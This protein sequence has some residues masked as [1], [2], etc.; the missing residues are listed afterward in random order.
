[1]T[2]SDTRNWAEKLGYPEG[3]KVLILHADDAGLNAEA[4]QAIIN[5]L[6]DDE[7]QVQS[8]SV[9]VPC[10]A[11]EEFV[12][13]GEQ[14]GDLDIG[15]HLTMTSEW[16]QYRWKSLLDRKVFPELFYNEEHGTLLSD[17]ILKS[18][19][20]VAFYV[21]PEVL[22]LEAIAQISRFRE[23]YGKAPSHIDTHM[24]VFLS[25]PELAK[26]FLEL[27]LFTSTPVNVPDLSKAFAT[28]HFQ[29][30]KLSIEDFEKGKLKNLNQ[31]R[32]DSLFED[33]KI[34]EFIEFKKEYK[35]HLPM[36]DNF[37]PVPIVEKSS[38][39]SKEVSYKMKKEFFEEFVKSSIRPGLTELF[40]HPTYPEAGKLIMGEDK[41]RQRLE[42]GK[43]FADTKVKEFLQKEGIIFTNW[44]E[45]MRRYKARKK[46]GKI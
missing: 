41:W 21:D 30:N 22:K 28:V 16:G 20:E 4:N 23:V 5:Y 26:A 29:K 14:N 40:F 36:L 25:T 37:L 12:E 15:V 13:W 39:Y 19:Q 6:N 27:A 46:A 3:S 35:K 17:T 18:W 44:K 31:E 42:E 10:K 8:A 9:M 7:A 24:G 45:M 38:K 33:R 34:N 32:I 11:F 2:E 43:M 1:M